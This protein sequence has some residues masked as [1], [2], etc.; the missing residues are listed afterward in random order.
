MALLAQVQG[1]LAEAE[2]YFRG[3]MAVYEEA[4]MPTRYLAAATQ[5]AGLRSW[6]LGDTARALQTLEDALEKYPLDSIEPASRP[7]RTLAGFYAFAGAPQRA[8]ELLVEYEAVV[9]SELRH[10]IAEA[11][12]RGRW[13]AVALAERRAEDALAGFR[14]YYERY[15]CPTCGLPLLGQAY[16]LA[17]QPDSALAMY[18]LY[19]ATPEYGRMIHGSSPAIGQGPFWLAVIYERLGDL[20]EQRGDTAKAIDH[21]GKLV[22]LWK[23]ADPELQPR[24][25]AARRAIEELSP[26]T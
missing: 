24:V 3:A 26:D 11:H 12:R 19:L 5:L 17:G 23:D 7:Y 15:A 25:E 10:G 20:Y 1:K 14:Y 6:F 18:E 16:E 2:G 13:G 4:D 9:P 22:D 21:Y 8:R